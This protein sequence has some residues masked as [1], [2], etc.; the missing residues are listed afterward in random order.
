MTQ[1]QGKTCM[2]TGAS[3]GIG[4]ATA[5]A[6]A[7]MGA[8]VIIVGR[9]PKKCDATVEHIK[10]QTGNTAVETMLADFAELAQVRR[11]AQ[12]FQR[13]RSRLHVL[14]N[15]AGVLPLTRRVSRDGYEMAFAVNHLAHFLLT[16]LLL[17]TLL[18]S[19]PARI[20]NVSSRS[21]RRG[22]IDFDD[23]QSEKHFSVGSVYG[24]SKIANVLFTYELAR[25]L[26]DSSVTVNALHPGFVRTNM[27]ADNGWFVRMMLPLIHIASLTPEE[28]AATS[29]YLAS[30]PEVEGVNGKYFAKCKPIRSSRDS[31]DRQAATRL[32]QESLKL[33]GLEA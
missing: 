32:W 14:V 17:D 10:Q 7:Q 1:M 24:K 12:D 22:P 11:L 26:E 13:K 21:H 18:A 4:K 15:N 8:E 27:A 2:I 5:F 16:N 19:A 20:V 31:Y 33:T 9:N 25:R 30:S 29:I 28:G 23:L 6:L 3:D